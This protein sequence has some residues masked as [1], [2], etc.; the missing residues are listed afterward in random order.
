MLKRLFPFILGLFGILISGHS[1]G[2]I[3]V[4]PVAG[5][6]ISWVSFHDSESRHFYKQTPVPTFQFGA[7]ASFQVRKNFLMHTA[8]LYSRKGENLTSDVDPDLKH[9]EI[10]HFID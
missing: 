7:G 8:V 2:Q 4:G 10:Y 5:G 1:V 9:K 3:L 6:G